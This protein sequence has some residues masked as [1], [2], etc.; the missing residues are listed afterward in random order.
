MFL[1]S[2]AAVKFTLIARPSWFDGDVL[3]H[4]LLSDDPII[5]KRKKVQLGIIVPAHG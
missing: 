1:L 3:K 5:G 4:P 2:S